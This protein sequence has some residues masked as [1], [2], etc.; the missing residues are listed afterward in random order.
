MGVKDRP[1]CYFDVEL[2]R[3]PIGRIVF[4]L[5][6]DICPKT[7]KNFLCLCTGERG[8]GK[9]TR[10]KL[11]YKGSTFHRVV[12][13]FM[14]Q[15]GDFTEGNGRGGESIYGGYFE[16]E[17][18]TLKHDRAF[19]LSMANRGKD[20]NGS[21]FFITTKMAPHLDGVHV[22][23]GLV[24]SGFEVIKKIEG[25]K[26]DSAS[27]P[28]ADVR[29]VDCGQLITK[30]ANDVLEG[31][32]KRTSHS[33]DS[34]LSS[35]DSFS[36]FSSLESESELDEKHRHYKQKRHSKSKRP[37][38]KRRLSRKDKDADS[39]P[40]KQSPVGR[41]LREGENEVEEEREL[42]GKREKPVVRPEEIPPVPENRFLLRRD[43][44]SQE[45]KAEIVEKE[46]A[47]LPA[48]LK[49]AVS[50]SGR[51]IR[52]RGTIRYH[53]PTRSKSR[54]ASVEERG[55]SETPPHWKE[56]EMKR[57]KM[58]QPPSIE[59]WSKGDKWDNR[60]DSA[61]SQSAE[62]SSDRSSERSSQRC[63]Q[64]KA[65][66]KSKHKK[67]A[68]K[69]KH[70]KKKSSKSKHQD[71]SDGERSVSSEKGFRKSRSPT[72]SSSSPHHSSNRRRRRSSRSYR[73]SRSYSKS[74][75][76]SRSRSRGR[77]LSYSRSR[78]RSGSRGR[79]FSRS[80]SRSWSHSHSRSK[81]RYRSRSRSLTPPRKRSFSRSPRK[82][83]TS[84]PDAMIPVSEKLQ[85]SK[86]APVPRLPA[87]PAPESVP[88]IPLSDSP[89]PSRWK[90]GQKPWKPSYI[91]IQ[92]IKAKVAPSNISSTGQAV[93]SAAEKAQ[94]SAT[95]KSLPGDS[96]DNTAQK[97]SRRSRSSSSRS[98]SY[99]RS[100]SR[101]RSR[102]Y[103]RSRSRSTNRH[104]SRSSSYSRSE[105]EK[106]PKTSNAKKES[107]DKEWK[108]YYSSLSRVKNLDKL[109]SGSLSQ[110]AHSGS[111]I[112]TDSE[113]SPGVI[114]SVEK[115]KDK[116]SSE[117]LE[118]KHYSSVPAESFNSR[119][120][121]DS[122]SDKVSQSNSTIPLKMQMRVAQYAVSLE[123]KL[124]SISGWN[125]ESDSENLTARTLAISEKEEGEAS[126]ES[127]YEIS[128]KT[129]DGGNALAASGQS[130][131]SPEKAAEPEKR[132]SKKKAK[133][134]HKHKRRSENKGGSHHSKDK[135][136]KTKRKHQKLKE[137]FHW[138]PPLEFEEEEE[139]DESK[140]ERHSPGRVVKKSPDVN[141]LNAKDQTASC[142]PT[143]EEERGQQRTKE[144]IN[145]NAKHTEP[146]L[147]SSNRNRTSDSH[148][149]SVQEP[150]TLDDMDICTPE[151]DAEIVEPSVPCHPHNSVPKI[152]L[153]STSNS[154]EME[155]NDTALSHSK[156]QSAVSSTSTAG[157]S[158]DKGTAG[159]PAATVINL[160]WRPLKGT[161]AVQNVNAPP[162][163]V[164]NVQAQE[165]Q[166]G[167][168]QG[169]R[170]EIKSKSRVR[171]GSLFDEVRKTARLN[172]RPRN[173]ESSSE[174]RSPSVGKAKGTRS[175][176][177]SRSVSRKSRSVSSH[178][179]RSRGWS[180]SYSRSRSRS[181]S[182]S[183][184]SRSRSRSWRRRGRG[185]SRSRS[186]TYRSYRSHSRTYSRS[187]SRS[188]SY[189]RRRRSRSDSYDSYSS[190]SRSVSRRRGR[191]R[192]D[193]YRSSDRRSRSYGSSSRSSSRRRSHS[194]SSRYS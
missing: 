191:R 122:D 39:L 7:S 140:R 16:D 47:T 67:K 186:T 113:C 97:P 190:R 164:K 170:M 43:M 147:E 184:S 23:F 152:T 69:R 4:Q 59:R 81:S 118:T 166:T 85:E 103:S 44:P 180:H 24:I 130:E 104:K 169:V 175:P 20:T 154:S 91:H 89:P 126:S 115:I 100:Y 3:E 174:E 145:K 111:E 46:E 82:K 151:H 109:I 150:E 17:N 36:Q 133:R 41:E 49:P 129:S 83:K 137:T 183:Y 107:L 33:A 60:S 35:H 187:H 92:E 13:N 179:S 127:D 87:V 30:S 19:L 29:V 135:A 162:V 159:K 57:T 149:P 167:N 74:Y 110:D 8:T 134:K 172:Q 71:Q 28:Y 32:R 106:S 40:S 55:S 171:P 160:K 93:D 176:K 136:K 99:S 5:F 31:K 185:R 125:S 173:Q 143:K 2:N 48:D 38:K 189:I 138:Q 148:W 45:D 18:F 58:Y 188:R 181:R 194:R 68:K 1:Q 61:W 193:S 70:N 94:T 131:E 144:G 168:M 75:T 139:E 78:S 56:E 153:K 161:S 132:K 117:D 14:I 128:R 63:Q 114:G 163:T 95:P 72:R 112:R 12:K 66:K 27:R 108:E 50:K 26:T 121:W 105:S 15:G 42:G 11:C 90:P 21:Q 77:S 178:R 6:S 79:S 123:K 98:R 177:T 165:N 158:Q 34:S 22:V 37:K 76:S 54:S 65:K 73:D 119:T 116:G 52:G 142:N 62:H 101:S 102:S 192:S 10:K 124:S 96:E 86:V 88:V 84:K 156:E 141:N 25:L 80:R 53:T 182:S 157:G 9:V 51:K 146:H 155:N 64:K 120:E